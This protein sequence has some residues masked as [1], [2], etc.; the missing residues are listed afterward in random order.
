MSVSITCDKCHSG[1]GGDE[2]V[3]C[4]ECYSQVENHL[5]AI[6]R[7]NVYQDLP[8]VIHTL[9]KA[10]GVPPESSAA[11]VARV[12]PTLEAQEAYRML[13]VLVPTDK[14]GC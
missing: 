11:D 8:D 14:G 1:L 3:Y 6:R 13:I 12:F 9:L 5:N 4:Y 2:T 10:L 7:G